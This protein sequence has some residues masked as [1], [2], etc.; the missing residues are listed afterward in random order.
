[1]SHQDPT[2]TAPLFTDAATGQL[3]QRKF[4]LV[5]TAGSDRGLE[6]VLDA[7]TTL[8]GTHPG[9]DIVLSDATVS[10]YHLE[11]QVRQDGLLIK[12]LDTT[13]GTQHG[14]T[15]LGQVTVTG[16][17]HLRLGKWTEIDLAPADVTVALADYEGDRFGDVLGAAPSMRALF[18][19][20]CR[21]A[22]TAAT[23]LL[24]GETGTGKEVLAEAVHARSPRAG[25]PF[26]VVDCGAI[27]KD[28]IQS[29]LFGHSRGAFTG[30][31]TDKIGL[32]EAASGGTLFLDEIGEL[33]LDLQPQLLRVLEKREVRR[34][35]ETRAGKVDIRVVAAT[36][37]DLA[38]QIARGAFREDLYFR[39][40]VVR[41]K[42]P[43][44]RE[45]PDDIAMLAH[46][47]AAQLGRG[48]F[49]LPAGV[50]QA[51]R[52]YPWP[53]NVRELRNA[54]ERG[55]SLGSP[56][57]PV[58]DG[59]APAGVAAAGHPATAAAGVSAARCDP[60]AGA[61][62]DR[63]FKEA[64]RELIEAFERAYLRHLLAKHGGNIS[65]AATEAGIDRNYIHRL[66]NKYGD[67][68]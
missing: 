64:K 41:A 15:R 7:G 2:S 53:G 68:L 11:L 30:A 24:E 62:L 4:R 45:R 49:D 52:S 43:P 61:R 23:L 39:L 5:V 16:A 38:A 36:H 27:P 21:V 26:V 9:N 63:P 47:F 54:V 13:N 32:V 66:K 50:M 19:L 48:A 57:L 46:H 55:L 56:D 34:V 44:L 14:G 10:R 12:D 28:L 1:M 37:R 65:R 8:V 60:A 35:G 31:T 3:K 58:G 20:L 33:G 18:A 29:E 40:A 59:A 17:A 6:R 42:V 25:G 51:F 67:N 22:P